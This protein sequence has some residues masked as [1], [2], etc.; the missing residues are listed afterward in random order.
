MS[1]QAIIRDAVDVL[2]VNTAVGMQISV[3]QGSAGGTAVYVETQNPTTNSNGLL[4]LEIGTGTA[5]TGTFWTIDWSTGPYFLKTETDPTGGTA[6]TITGTT[7]LLS[8]PYALYAKTSDN[9]VPSGGT[10]GQVLQMVSGVATWVTPETCFDGIQ[11]QN[12]T[13]VDCGGICAECPP[14]VAGDCVVDGVIFYIFESGDAGYVPGETHGLIVSVDEISVAWD[15]GYCDIAALANVSSQ[16]GGSPPA[17]TEVDPSTMI[18]DGAGNTTAIIADGACETAAADWCRAKGVDWFLPSRGE[19]NELYK[20]YE[21]DK[22]ANNTLMT[23][24]GGVGF[25][26]TYYYWSS[27]EEGNFYAWLQ[28]FGNG[29]QYDADKDNGNYVRAVRAF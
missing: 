17:G 1:Y 14:P 23:N 10:E 16:L 20:W 3:L 7:E 29:I 12:E 5:T 15:D 13:G 2:L 25:E 9:G 21:T 6:Y 18:G 22:T 27:T 4:S 19:L 11:N 24:C 28:Y 26:P 8:V